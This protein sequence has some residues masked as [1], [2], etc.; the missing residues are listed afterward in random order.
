M[1]SSLLPRAWGGPLG[2][3]VLRSRPEDFQ[4]DEDLGFS[5]DGEG[6]HLLLRIRKRDANT[7]WVARRLARLAGVPLK[8]IGFAGLK[9]RH[10]VTTQWFSIDLAG[11]PE[12]DWEVLETEGIR[13]LEVARHGRKLRRGALRGNRFTLLLREL[14]GEREA[15]GQRLHLLAEKGVPNYFG[16]QRFG[17]NDTNLRQAAALFK[18]ELRVRDRHRRGLYLSAARSL[19]FNRVLAWRVSKGCWRRALP[20][21]VVL[22]SGS[23]SFFTVEALDEAIERRLAEGDL[24]PS[25][26]L[27]GRGTS[28]ARGEALALE[29]AA[30]Q[31]CET[32][33]KGLES[34]GMRQERRALCSRPEGLSWEWIG[35][36][37]LRLD[38]RL[39]AGEYATTLLRELVEPLGFP[40]GKG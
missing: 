38:F 28:P 14:Q 34:A 39:P 8:A 27:W 2:S 36:D 33:C 15:I 24:L 30:L 31:G 11:K 40:G 19:L 9:D 21:E 35:S 37:R 13:V 22:L 12:P 5:P 18:G 10:A 26:P 25:G 4:V 23:R 7:Q 17:R 6:Q 29:R 3:A 20:G 1:E 16:E 32:L